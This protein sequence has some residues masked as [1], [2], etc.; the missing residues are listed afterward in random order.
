MGHLDSIEKAAQT[1]ITLCQKEKHTKT[2]KEKMMEIQAELLASIENLAECE[3]CGAITE[4]IVTMTLLEV[5]AK[6]CQTCGVKA[7][8]AGKIQ[9]AKQSTRRRKRQTKTTGTK[10]TA[11]KTKNGGTAAKTEPPA[12]EKESP[13]ALHKRI[14]AETGIKKTDVRRLH[15]ILDGIATPMNP[16]HTFE[17]MQRE[18]EVAKIK[19]EPAVLAQAVTLLSETPS[20]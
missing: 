10:A 3:R 15:K 19:I 16:E 5:T 6:L 20:P 12:P 11:T 17:Y 13:A 18:A 9:P 8:E 2:D 14:E 7:L 4:L 1:L